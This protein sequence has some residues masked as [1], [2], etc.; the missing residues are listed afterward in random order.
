MSRMFKDKTGRPMVTWN[1]FIG[2]N[3]GCTYC[4]ARKAA[5][6]RMKH[7]PR[8]REGFKPRM[9]DIELLTTF[10]PGQFVFVGYMGDISFQPRENV[11]R[12]LQIIERYPETRFLF[13]SKNPAVYQEWGFDYPGN[14]YLG[15]TIESNVD[16][17]VSK[18]PPP[19]ER[20]LAMKELQHPRKFISIEPLMDFHLRTL[21]DWMEAIRP[22][23]IEVGADNYHNG[24]PEPRDGRA[25]VRTPWKVRWLLEMLREICPTVIEKDGLGRL[26]GAGK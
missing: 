7:S 17:G 14:L 26:T 2:C 6:T 1:V 25:S 5:L 24:L 11:G 21:V 23:I 13:C 18:S 8:Y 4:N 9:I 10:R 22:E 19:A 16:H 3:F 20:Y 15:A 12:V